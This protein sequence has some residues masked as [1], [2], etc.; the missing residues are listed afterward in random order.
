MSTNNRQAENPENDENEQKMS[1]FSQKT[2]IL[3]PFW[4]KSGQKREKSEID[5]EGQSYLKF[6]AFIS[7]NQI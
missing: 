6:P 5:D 4:V 3:T 7:C 1:D 2:T